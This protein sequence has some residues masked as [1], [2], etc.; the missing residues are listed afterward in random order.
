MASKYLPLTHVLRGVGRD[1]L[2]FGFDELDVMIGGLPASA[3][4]HRSWWGNAV[5]PR[6]VHAAAWLEAGWIVHQIDLSR[7]RVVFTRGAPNAR[8]NNRRSDE[9]DGVRQL[10]EVLAKAGYPTTMHAVAKHTVMLHP[11]T[12]AQTGLQP[13]FPTVRRNPLASEKVGAFGVVNGRRV[14]YD[15]NHSP[16]AAYLWAAG[17]GRGR[18]VQYNHI[19]QAR[20][21]V[22]SYTA[23]WNLCLTPAFLAKTTDG[24]NHPDVTRALQYRTW[25]LFGALPAGEPTPTPPDRYDE[26]EWADPPPALPDLAAAYRRAMRSKPKDRVV[27]AARDV[28]WLYSGWQPDASL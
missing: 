12:V 4:I 6:H 15:D 18:D 24:N 27:V 7:E 25:E 8:A 28:G 10:A 23:L 5:N 17:H 1:R 13:V 14:M 9:P 16:T 11:E 22:T 26:L 19:W 21:D 3:R 20:Q 2:E